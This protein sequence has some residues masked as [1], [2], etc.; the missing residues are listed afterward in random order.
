MRAK[1]PLYREMC[2]VSDSIWSFFSEPS[3][4]FGFRQR[5]FGLFSIWSICLRTRQKGKKHEISSFLDTALSQEI[6]LRTPRVLVRFR[7]HAS[8]LVHWFQLC[9]APTKSIN[10]AVCQDGMYVSGIVLSD[11]IRARFHAGSSAGS[12]SGS[13]MSMYL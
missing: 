11:L 3:L 10:N 4:N 12:S 8:C 1:L 7:T 9:I 5:V 2:L 13:I 6:S